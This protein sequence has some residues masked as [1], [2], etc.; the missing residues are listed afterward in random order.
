MNASVTTERPTTEIFTPQQLQ[1]FRR[2]GF[3]AARQLFSS[4]EIAEIRETFMD[5]AKDGPI[6]GLSEIRRGKVDGNNG[7]YDPADPLAF[8]PR[9]MHPHLHDEKSVGKVALK[10]LLDARLEAALTA[11]LQDE[12]VAVQSMFYFKPPGA[13]GQALH[14]DNFYLRVSPG[15]CMAAWVAVD[16]ADEENGGMMCVPETSDLDIACP[17]KADPARF[18]TTDHVSPPAGKEPQI[19][20]LKAGDVLFF[21]GSVIHGSNPNTS[22]DRFRRS[23]IFHYVP[24]NAQELSHWYK[25]PLTF[26]G[27]VLEIAQATGGGPCG[28]LE[29]SMGAVH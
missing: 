22:K 27:E 23:L 21:N 25:R 5:A 2:D 3:I 13:R 11:L 7:G 9:M 8:Y 29:A 10:Y 19:V 15:T 17:E 26:R 14:Q 4:A 16:D 24:R 28:T 18:F 20:R 12:P 6:D 1:Q